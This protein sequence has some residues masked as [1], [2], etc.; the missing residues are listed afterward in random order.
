MEICLG[1]I[2]MSPKDFW[3]MSPIEMYATV[4]GFI[5]FHTSKKDEPMSKEELDDLMELYPD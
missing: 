2:K 4:E 1:M 5:E 3:S